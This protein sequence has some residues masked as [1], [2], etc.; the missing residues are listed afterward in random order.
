MG[1]VSS[2]EVLKVLRFVIMISQEPVSLMPLRENSVFGKLN[3]ELFQHGEHENVGGALSVK[4]SRDTSD[5]LVL[6]QP[7]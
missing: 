7:G 3:L 4:F 2:S 6:L 5:T 1:C